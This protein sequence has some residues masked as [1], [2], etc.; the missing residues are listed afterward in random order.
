MIKN[1]IQLQVLITLYGLVLSEPEVFLNEDDAGARFEE[2]VSAPYSKYEEGCGFRKRND[3]ETWSKYAKAFSIWTETKD[4]PYDPAMDFEIKWYPVD[5]SGKHIELAMQLIKDAG[6][7][8]TYW[9]A[10]DIRTRAFENY[11]SANGKLSDEDCIKILANIEK[12]QN[13]ETGINWS[14][15]DFEISNFLESK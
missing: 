10:E 13:A 8:A 2:I 7:I 15:I 11:G 14:V 5:F 6:M 1:E 4:C 12:S 3:G 9:S